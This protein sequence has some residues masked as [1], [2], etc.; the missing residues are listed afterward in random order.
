MS[1]SYPMRNA[2]AEDTQQLTRST[3]GLSRTHPSTRVRDNR[4]V[5][6]TGPCESRPDGGC[7]SLKAR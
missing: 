7:L 2:N 6:A 3:C 5:S 1:T 4:S